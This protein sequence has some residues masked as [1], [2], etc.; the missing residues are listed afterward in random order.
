MQPGWWFVLQVDKLGDELC[1]RGARRK[2]EAPDCAHSSSSKKRFVNLVAQLQHAL[3]SM[4]SVHL[5]F[6]AAT[7]SHMTG[8]KSCSGFLLVQA[9]HN[10][11]NLAPVDFFPVFGMQQSRQSLPFTFPAATDL[12]ANAS[13][14]KNWRHL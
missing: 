4:Q 11:A 8:V 10:L 2:R 14:E 3:P 5:R 1:S 9:M 12:L 13:A 6:F 7:L